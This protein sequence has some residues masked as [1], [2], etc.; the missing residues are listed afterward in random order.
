[1]VRTGQRRVLRDALRHFDGFRQEIVGRH[2][3]I[4]KPH[5]L[6]PGR[7]QQLGSHHQFQHVGNANHLGELHRKRRHQTPL[8]FRNTQPGIVGGQGARRTSGQSPRPPAAA[9]PLTAA[10]RGLLGRRP[11]VGPVGR[12]TVLSPGLYAFGVVRGPLLQIPA[13]AEVPPQLRSPP[14]PRPRRHR[15]QSG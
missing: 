14:P 9:A 3:P 6:H 11:H 13:G 7:R 2:H 4:E 15:G 10:T 1:M 12:H 8:G 5:L